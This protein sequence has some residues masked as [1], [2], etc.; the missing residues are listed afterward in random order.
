MKRVSLDETTIDEK[1]LL[2]DV[3]RKYQNDE[4]FKREFTR[5]RKEFPQTNLIDVIDVVNN[6]RCCLEC[7]GLEECQQKNAGYYLDIK[8]DALIY[9]ACHYKQEKVDLKKKYETL[10]YSTSEQLKLSQIDDHR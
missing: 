5:L 4:Y 10:I 2:N 6:Q 9:R 3:L 1:K 8:D 7:Q